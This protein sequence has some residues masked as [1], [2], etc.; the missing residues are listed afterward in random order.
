MLFS[1]ILLFYP[2]GVAPIQDPTVDHHLR[3]WHAILG[4]APFVVKPKLLGTFNIVVKPKLWWNPHCYSPKFCG[5]TLQLP[6][7]AKHVQFRPLLS[8]QN[9]SIVSAVACPSPTTDL[10]QMWWNFIQ[11]IFDPSARRRVMAS[12]RRRVMGVLT[13]TV[14]FVIFHIHLFDWN[15]Q[16]FDSVTSADDGYPR[17]HASLQNVHICLIEKWNNYPYPSSNRLL[18]HFDGYFEESTPFGTHPSHLV[19]THM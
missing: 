19:G 16:R 12:A 5:E 6:E 11:S 13:R 17:R 10:D 18:Y 15:L 7:P 14:L 2:F 3:H 1:Q 9:H 8:Q 4:Y